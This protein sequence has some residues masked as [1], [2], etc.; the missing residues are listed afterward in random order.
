MMSKDWS[1][2]LFLLID[3]VSLLNGRFKSAFAAVRKSV[4]LGETEMTVL[5]SVVQAGTP[6]T[7]PQI[8][9]SLGIARQLVQRAANS[10]KEQGLI[11]FLPN[12]DHKRALLLAATAKGTALKV[13]ADAAGNAIVGRLDTGVDLAAVGDAA[14]QLQRI[15][16]ELEKQLNTGG[17]R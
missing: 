1:H 13:E 7:V 8:G 4:G 9:R 12:P 3:E 14:Q 15:R 16:K 10:L 6:P 5:N 2:P 17:Y 11:E